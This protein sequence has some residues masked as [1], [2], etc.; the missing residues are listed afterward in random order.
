MLPGFRSRRHPLA[1]SLIERVCNLHG[2]PERFINW[3]R[4]AFEALRQSLAIQVLHDK[5]MNSVLLADVMKSADMRMIETRYRARLAL[6]SLT[7][8][9]ALG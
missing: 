4:A 3:N 7:S 2:I 8:L 6:E 5:K 9:G 1:V